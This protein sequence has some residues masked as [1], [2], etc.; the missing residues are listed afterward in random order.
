M[1][2]KKLFK[3]CDFKGLNEW[4]KSCLF[5][6]IRRTTP[7]LN[8]SSVRETGLQLIVA[9]ESGKKLLNIV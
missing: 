7:Q 2:L 4:L 1:E 5:F 6:V 8:L 3:S 9:E